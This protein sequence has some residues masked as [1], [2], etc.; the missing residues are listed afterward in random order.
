[1]Y[2][3]YGLLNCRK[4]QC[5]SGNNLSLPPAQ[6]QMD[7]VYTSGRK[8]FWFSKHIPFPSPWVFW[9]DRLICLIGLC[10]CWE[11]FLDKPCLLPKDECQPAELQS[12]IRGIQTQCLALE[13]LVD[14]T[15]PG[16]QLMVREGWPVRSRSWTPRDLQ[17]ISINSSN[18]LIFSLFSELIAQFKTRRWPW[19][20]SQGWRGCITSS[21][22]WE[23]LS[24]WGQA[25]LW[26]P[27]P[28][29]FWTG[30]LHTLQ[31]HF[32]LP[33]LADWGGRSTPTKDGKDLWM[34]NKN[35][36]FAWSDANSQTVAMFFLDPFIGFILRDPKLCGVVYISEPLRSL[37]STLSSTSSFPVNE[38]SKYL[39]SCMN[40]LFH[41]SNCK[42]NPPK[43]PI[44][45]RL[46]KN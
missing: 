12:W 2:G 13:E 8:L 3:E 22:L 28:A 43:S 5:V 19:L 36:L 29:G 33:R 42:L 21:D 25:C 9:K 31:A 32:S 26:G 24:P 41:L 34:R 1:M 38:S 20:L 6:T 46:L 4:E 10:P 11:E 27:K 30:T 18:Q 45:L 23:K 14:S 16:K 17:G 40:F 7:L 37:S 44:L 39:L 15:A 35:Y